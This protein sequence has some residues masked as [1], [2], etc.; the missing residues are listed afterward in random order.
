MSGVG[1][2]L[3][4]GLLVGFSVLIALVLLRPLR[5]VIFGMFTFEKLALFLLLFVSSFLVFVTPLMLIRLGFFGV[6]RLKLVLLVL[7]FLLV[8]LPFRVPVVMLVVALSL[9]TP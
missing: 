1:H 9:F 4:F 2:I 5:F 6:G 3:H 8:A 7:I